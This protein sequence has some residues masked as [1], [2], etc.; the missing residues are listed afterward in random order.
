MLTS[1]TSFA[2]LLPLIYDTSQQSQMLVPMAVS[3]GF[4][5][6]FAAA[7][8]LFLVPSAFLV[9]PYW[10]Q[11]GDTMDIIDADALKKTGRTTL[12]FLASVGK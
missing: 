1:L 9:M 4:G 12:R 10:H 7:I 2:G 3:L 6:L 11:Q 8:T 5:L